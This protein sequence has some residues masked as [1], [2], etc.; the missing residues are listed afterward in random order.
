MAFEPGHGGPDAHAD[1]RDL[2]LSL[3]SHAAH[4]GQL[5]HHAGEDGGGR[6][7]GIAGEEAAPGVDGP[8]HYGV[9]A[10]KELDHGKIPR[11]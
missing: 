11:V 4:L 2:V 8:T 10:F 5:A 3:H 7:D 9:V 6:G 1:G